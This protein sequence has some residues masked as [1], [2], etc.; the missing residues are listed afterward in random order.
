MAVLGRL[1]QGHG[2]SRG[3]G[4]PDRVAATATVRPAAPTHRSRRAVAPGR[5][6]LDGAR[7][8]PWVQDAETQRC[9]IRLSDP[10]VVP[11]TNLL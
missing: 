10:G 7:T 1:I 9:R 4:T 2:G 6:L 5:S 8:A 11:S 3:M